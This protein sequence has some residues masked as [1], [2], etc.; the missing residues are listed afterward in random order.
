MNIIEINKKIEITENTLA[1][2]KKT[3]IE[4]MQQKSGVEIAHILDVDKS[5]VSRMVAK[6]KNINYDNVIKFLK[7]I[8]SNNQTKQ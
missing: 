7:K 4:E 3:L 6:K 2:L 5:H 8:I 1:F